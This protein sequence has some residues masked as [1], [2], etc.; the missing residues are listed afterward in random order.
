MSTPIG[1][2]WQDGSYESGADGEGA[3]EAPNP[4]TGVGI[5][6]TEGEPTTF[7]PEEPTDPGEV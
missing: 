7:E 4:E 1:P 2:E 6:A 5:G 3:G